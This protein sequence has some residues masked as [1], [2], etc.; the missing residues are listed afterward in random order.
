MSTQGSKKAIVAA[1]A[2]NLGIALAKFV[3]FIVTGASS[4]LAESIH[5]LADTGNQGLLMLGNRRAQ[6]D[7]DDDHPFGHGRERFFYAFVV[8]MVLFTVGSVFAIVEGIDKIRHPE[9]I[10]SVAVAL[11][12]LGI[13]IVLEAVSLRT[14]M[15]ESRAATR[16][17]HGWR[18][19]IHESKTPELT[20]LLLEDVAALVG[21]VVAFAAL[22]L[23]W[24]VD[25]VFD[26]I[27]TLTIGAILGVVAVVLAV[28]MKSLLLGEAA[29]KADVDLIE[30]AIRSSAHVD[31]LIHLRTQHLGPKQLLIAAKV[32]FSQAL[33]MQELARAI[34]VVEESIRAVV[35]GADY[36]FIEPDIR[37][38]DSPDA[39]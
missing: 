34:D 14:A 32:A 22:L 8:A 19:F 6:R 36:I 12:V 30:A 35:D 37:R 39:L 2:A 1:F 11:V 3:G 10:E 26:G 24:R 23:A 16:E 31:S 18:A 7:V 5:S 29:T 25:A 33:S 28:E 17:W 38:E 20:V 21:L 27:G 9:A 4:M 15:S 13:A